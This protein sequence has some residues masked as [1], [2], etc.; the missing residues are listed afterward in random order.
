MNWIAAEFLMLGRYMNTVNGVGKIE[1]RCYKLTEK[2]NNAI[3]FTLDILRVWTYF[4]DKGPDEIS[5]EIN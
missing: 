2:Y 1:C 3:C 5:L 4:I